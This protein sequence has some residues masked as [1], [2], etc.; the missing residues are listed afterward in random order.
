[1]A[2]MAGRVLRL[3]RVADLSVEEVPVEEIIREMFR[4]P[5]GD[6]GFAK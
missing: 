2:D 1:V 5:N 3:G 4:S 6:H